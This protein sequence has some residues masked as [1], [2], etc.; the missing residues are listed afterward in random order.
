[1][2][3]YIAEHGIITVFTIRY[4]GFH[5]IIA[6]FNYLGVDKQGKIHV[7]WSPALALLEICPLDDFPDE[8]WPEL[9]CDPWKSDLEK[10]YRSQD[11]D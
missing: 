3:K 11:S 2:A 10:L 5:H 4:D 7:F 8:K 6:P 1:M 9:F